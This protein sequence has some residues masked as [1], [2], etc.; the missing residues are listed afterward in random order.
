MCEYCLNMTK[1]KSKKLPKNLKRAL[2]KHLLKRIKRRAKVQ[3]FNKVLKKKVANSLL[4][5]KGNEE[6]ML[7]N[8]QREAAYAAFNMDQVATQNDLKLL[9]SMI[10]DPTISKEKKLALQSYYDA[11]SS[12]QITAKDRDAFFGPVQSA[13]L[14]SVPYDGFKS[15]ND[16]LT[17][18]KNSMPDLGISDNGPLAKAIANEL[19]A[20]R[21]L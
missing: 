10:N 7:R 19:R 15:V 4:S 1:P 20:R 13:L 3:R 11:L 14:R 17:Y 8:K 18:I 16:N 21:H 5:L 2:T 6:S 12:G 9:P